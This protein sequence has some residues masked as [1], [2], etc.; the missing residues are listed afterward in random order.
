[1]DRGR[2]G[3]AYP[4]RGKFIPLMAFQQRM[5]VACV[6][7]SFRCTGGARDDPGLPVESKTMKAPPICGVVVGRGCQLCTAD[8]GL[9]MGVH[10]DGGPLGVLL[11]CGAVVQQG[12]WLILAAQGHGVG[13]SRGDLGPSPVV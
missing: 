4:L 5:Q 11:W 3:G 7:Q 6:G 12:R 13:R 9:W 10:G 8:L 2:W 1:M